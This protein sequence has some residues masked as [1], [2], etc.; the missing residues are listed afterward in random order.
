ML[1]TV[2]APIGK[3]NA[4]QESAKGNLPCSAL[5]TVMAK[6]KRSHQSEAPIKPIATNKP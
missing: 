5:R 3:T 6:A 2:I 4:H 1:N